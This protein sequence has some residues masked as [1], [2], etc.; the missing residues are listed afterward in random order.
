MTPLGSP[1][2]P[3]ADVRPL[4]DAGNH[5]HLY[6]DDALGEMTPSVRALA[7]VGLCVAIAMAEGFDAQAMAFAAP[8]V[9]RQW[10]LGSSGIGI[11]LASSI[12]A[13]VVAGFVLAPLGDRWGRRPA[14]LAA[15]AVTSVATAAGAVAPGFGWLLCARVLAGLGLGLAFPTVIALAMEIMPR[16]FHALVVVAVSCGYPIGGA[17]GGFVVAQLIDGYG[18]A[19]IFLLGGATT[20]ALLCICIAALTESPLWLA[21][22][23]P[24]RPDLPRLIRRLG[25]VVP[26][27]AV[28]FGMRE[29][30]VAKSPVAALFTPERRPRTVLLSS[31]NFCNLSMVYFYI[32]WLP[33]MLVNAGQAA[34]FAAGAL[35]AF[36]GAGVIGGL[37]FAFGLRRWGAGKALGAA[38]SGS[39]VFIGWLAVTSPTDGLFMPVLVC[40]GAFVVGSQ[41]CL[42]AVVNQYYPSS[43]RAT[44]SGF[45]GGVGRLGAVAA[46]L[47]G[48]AVI[49]ATTPFGLAAAVGAVPAGLALVCLCAMVVLAPL[50]AQNGSS[51]ASASA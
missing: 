12:V 42:N 7:L 27:Q 25:A 2:G 31:I 18:A 48:A 47:V 24:A 15:L 39:L 17:A 23:D 13:M 35:A 30:R 38:Y 6:V 43:I 3:G 14:I 41:F 19:S 9:S 20:A 11:L 26:A 5:A 10:A 1:I 32:I 40:A 49:T 45:T 29:G 33:T 4:P 28:T 51:R 44:A 21:G 36:S 37:A 8:L 50:R 46:P 34:S 22:R 16:R